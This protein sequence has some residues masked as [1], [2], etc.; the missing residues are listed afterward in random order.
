L[1]AEGLVLVAITYL[2]ARAG[3]E[4]SSVRRALAWI[5]GIA[6]LPL[7][8]WAFAERREY[9]D[10]SGGIARMFHS[11]NITGWAIAIVRRWRWRCAA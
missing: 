1:I 9:W 5:G 2:S 11:P 3:Q 6:F 4:D 8:V 7:S 10:G